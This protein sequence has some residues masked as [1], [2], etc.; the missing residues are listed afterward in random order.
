[1][2]SENKQQIWDLTD[3]TEKFAYNVI[4]MFKNI[5]KKIVYRSTRFKVNKMTILLCQKK[6]TRKI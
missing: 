1:M 3:L 2:I 6:N 5:F 4:M